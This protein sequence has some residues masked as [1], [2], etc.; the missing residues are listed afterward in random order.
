MFFVYVQVFK[1]ILEEAEIKIQTLKIFLNEKL[2]EM[3]STL[4]QQK[5]II[6]QVFFYK[7]ILRYRLIVKI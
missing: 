1:M 3:P 5:K 2:K 7:C 6:R 4:E